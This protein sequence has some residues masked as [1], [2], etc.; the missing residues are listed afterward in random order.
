MK[1]YSS[2]RQSLGKHFFQDRLAKAIRYDRIAGYFSSSM[3]EIAGEEIEKMPGKVRMIANSSLNPLDVETAKAANQALTQEW[4]QQIDEL[5]NDQ[6]QA[7]FVRLYELLKSGKLEIRILPDQAFGLVHGK[8]GVLTFEDG[9][10]TSFL[11]SANESKSGWTLN[12]ELIWEDPSKES[13]AWVQEEFDALWSDGRAC[14]LSE[15]IVIDIKRLGG[16]KVVPL[17][18]WQEQP[19]PEAA[20]V[21][22]PIYREHFGLWGHQKYFVK[23]AYEEHRSGRGARFVLADQVGLGKTVQLAMA[24]MLMALQSD[25][26]VLVIAPKTLMYQWQDELLKLLGLPSAVWDQNTWIDETGHIYANNNPGKAIVKCPRRFGIISQGLVIHGSDVVYRLLDKEYE[27][28]IVDEA[29]R[30]RR[31]NLKEK[32]QEEP[33]EPNNLMSYLLQISQRTKSMLLG[34]ATPV[35]LY[36]IEAYDLLCV[37]GAGAPH[38]LGNDFSFWRTQSKDSGFKLVDGT[39]RTFRDKSR[40][41]EWLR[42]PFPPAYENNRLFGRIRRALNMSPTDYVIKPNVID[43]LKPGYKRSIE[44]KKR[45]FEQYNP[46]VR[47]II[48]R[49][50]TFLEETI[51][52]E[53][54]EPYLKKVEVILYGEESKDAIPLKGYLEDA[55]QTATEFSKSLGE[56]MKGSGFIK[57]LLLR[58]IGSSMEAGRKT[59]IKMLGNNFDF[60]EEE[61]VHDELKSGVAARIGPEQQEI[62]KRLIRQLDEFSESDPKL[63]QLNALLFSYGWSDLGCIIF[64]Q[65]YDTVRYFS[66]MVAREHP[67]KKIGVYAGAGKSGV[68]HKGLYQ[69]VEKDT[70]KR[71]VQN[72]EIRILF[73]TDSAS[74]GLNLQ[75]LGTLINLDLPWNPTRLEQRKGRIQ[76]IGQR[77][78]KVKVYNMRYRGTVE[79]RVHELLSDR[80]NNIFSIFGQIP[81]V[82]QDIWVDMAMGEKEKAQER[83]QEVETRSAFEIRY[84]RIDNT[85][86]ESCERVLNKVDV[87]EALGKGW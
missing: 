19:E 87:R 31:R 59:A 63:E 53:T 56:V 24:A 58:R 74:E 79:D 28:V 10:Q 11:G 61:D 83:I 84:D 85:D 36:P 18:K 86:F 44:R 75:R 41:W 45:L 66:E 80:L 52:E 71:A 64:S 16:R 46:Y 78:D 57:T 81:D 30:S 13:V 9:S 15:A 3:L 21:E 76:R 49:T 32:G 55:Y 60:T 2:R 27:C 14:S 6:L 39:A 67:D 12:Y 5:Y 1:R 26:P 54:G 40:L 4:K 48:R 68:W 7:R 69:R 47:H 72:D 20:I 43:E 77:L 42:N 62:L 8:A 34:T 22:N 51:N 50:R 37:L 65:Y 73:G 23:L 17:D 29:H 25:K 33:A 70:I 35:Q 82:L 38:V